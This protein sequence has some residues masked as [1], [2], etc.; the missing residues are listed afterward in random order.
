MDT[1]YDLIGA[2][3]DDDADRLKKAYRKAA[4]A[5]HPDHHGDDPDAVTRFTEITAAY[6][7][8]R[9]DGQRAAYDRML[10]ARRELPERARIL[11]GMS[12]S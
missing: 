7:V 11:I 8:L 5:T 10:E 4:K 9:D 6:G 3:P 2:G 12:F 1:L